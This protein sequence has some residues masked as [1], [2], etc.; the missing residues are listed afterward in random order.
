[1]TDRNSREQ[2][3]QDFLASSSINK[4]AICEQNHTSV[5]VSQWNLT[6]FVYTTAIYNDYTL[7]KQFCKLMQLN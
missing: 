2:A 7:T 1:M 6:A 3:K 4:L 5:Y